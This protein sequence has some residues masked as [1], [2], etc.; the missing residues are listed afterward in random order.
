VDSVWAGDRAP[1]SRTARNRPRAAQELTGNVLGIASGC[2][3]GKAPEQ[4]QPPQ[5][6]VFTSNLPSLDGLRVLVVDDEADAR[7]LLITTLGQYAEVTAVAAVGEAPYKLR[8]SQMPGKRYWHA[9]RR[10]LRTDSPVRA[11]TRAS[12]RIPA[13]ALT[14]YARAEDRYRLGWQAFSYTSLSQSIQLS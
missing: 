7:E 8:C 3:S 13:V 11:L 9:G 4:I 14:A 6:E 12:G 2:R 10:R 5:N 1:L